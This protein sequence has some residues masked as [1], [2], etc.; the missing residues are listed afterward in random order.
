MLAFILRI[1]ETYFRHRF[2]HLLPVP[3]LLAAGVAMAFTAEPSFIASSAIMVQKESVLVSLADVRDGGF[4]WVTPAEATADEFK[5]LLSTDAFIWA[6]IQQT[7]LS[8]EATTLEASK[9]L[10]QNVRASVWA[11]PWGNQLVIVGAAHEKP[12]IAQQLV[13]GCTDAFINWKSSTEREDA[14]AAVSFFTAQ[15]EV[16]AAEMGAAQEGIKQYEE[17]H[18]EPIR[19]E[20]PPSELADLHD[21][22]Q[23][24]DVAADLFTS[25]R[26]KLESA[27]HSLAL[28]ASKASQTYPIIDPPKLPTEPSKSKKDKAMQAAIF[29]VLGGVVAAAGVVLLALLDQSVRFE[30]DVRHTFDLPVLVVLPDETLRGRAAR[31]A[32]KEAKKAR[33]AAAEDDPS[34]AEDQAP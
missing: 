34:V 18:P 31:K 22:E 21:L 8:G 1:L 7:D 29:G 25:A 20:R 24:Y 13:Q 11:T 17:A 19:G 12:A 30:I 26:D 32:R 10:I 27:R 28:A 33:P 6:I 9:E 2:L 3:V 15:L 16:Y 5:E 23:A 14:R 4:G